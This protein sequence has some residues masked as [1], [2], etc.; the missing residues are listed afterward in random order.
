MCTYLYIVENHDTFERQLHIPNLA[1]KYHSTV[2]IGN[3]SLLYNVQLLLVSWL[4]WSTYSTLVDVVE[5]W[6]WQKWQGFND[7]NKI[8]DV[9]GLCY[10]TYTSEFKEGKK[11][12][13]LVNMLWNR[14]PTCNTVPLKYQL[15]NCNILIVIEFIVNSKSQ[16]MNQLSIYS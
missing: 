8:C 16:Y 7:N 6:T 11:P 12:Q 10:V 1:T 4:H 5:L 15:V 14:S 2:L 3:R 9:F 13:I